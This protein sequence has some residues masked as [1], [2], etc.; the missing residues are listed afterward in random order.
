MNH[1]TFQIECIPEN[2]DLIFKI[3]KHLLP[4][5]YALISE[6]DPVTVAVEIDRDYDKPAA[7][8]YVEDIDTGLSVSVPVEPDTTEA[9][10]AEP[11]EPEEDPAVIAEAFKAFKKAGKAAKKD[12]GVEF[13]TSVIAAYQDGIDTDKPMTKILASVHPELYD[14]I[15]ETW[16]GGPDKTPSPSLFKDSDIDA[17]LED[18]PTPPPSVASVK[19]ALKKLA[20]NGGKEGAIELMSKHN[21]KFKDLDGID[22]DALRSLGVAL[23]IQADSE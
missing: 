7:H 3:Q 18:D 21:T 12:H 5:W 16:E 15:C 2:A 14:A 20:K 4:N 10:E 9:I 1:V 23:N 8:H 6:N 17:E 13:L 22:D 11:V 19:L